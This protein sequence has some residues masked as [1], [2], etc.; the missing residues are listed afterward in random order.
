MRTELELTR[1]QD[2][3]KITKRFIVDTRDITLTLNEIV[4]EDHHQ[5]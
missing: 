3:S 4:K 1:R 2:K 5:E